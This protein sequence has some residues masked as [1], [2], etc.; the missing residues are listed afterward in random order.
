MSILGR[1]QF[2]YEYVLHDIIIGGVELYSFETEFV[3]ETRV[4]V[5][6]KDQKLVLP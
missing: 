4:G 2:Y 1:E 6:G 5:I 3:P